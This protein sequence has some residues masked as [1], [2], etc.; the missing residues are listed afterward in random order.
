MPET[1]QSNS[2][3]FA[4]EWTPRSI[5][6]HPAGVAARGEASLRLAR[7]LLQLDDETLALFQG[8][9][10]AKTLIVMAPEELLP[11]VD[12][13]QYLGVDAAVPSLLS[14][15]NYQ[16]SVPLALLATSLATR[17]KTEG[18]LAVLPY[19]LPGLVV[20]MHSAKSIHRQ[21][22]TQWLETQ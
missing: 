2:Q 19:P 8:L 20:A 14:P 3:E 16:P 13:V 4:V 10:G 18:R 9:A 12:G 22:L 5:P 7:R 11:W 15:S 1:A 17:S 6:L 21:S